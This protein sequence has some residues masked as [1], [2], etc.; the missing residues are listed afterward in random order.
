VELSKKEGL[1]GKILI[2][3]QWYF[4]KGRIISLHMKINDENNYFV[5]SNCFVSGWGRKE[6]W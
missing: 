4:L 6:G 3:T 1:A 5:L 2:L